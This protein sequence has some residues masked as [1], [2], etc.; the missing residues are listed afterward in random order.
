MSKHN[1]VNMLSGPIFKNIVRFTVP[2]IL[3]SILQLLFN[4][5]DLIVVGRFCGS[6]SVAAVGATSPLIH[7]FINFFVGISAGAGVVAANA[8]GA[9][10]TKEIKK[11]VH[12]AIPLAFI[13]GA[14]LS[15]VG[16]CFSTPLLKL[17]RTPN[18]ILVLSSKYM[19]IYFAGM[20]ATMLYNFCAAILRAAGDTKSPLLALSTSGVIN[21]VLNII[22]VVLFH[23]DVVGVALATTIS[24]VVS[25]VLVLIILMRRND[26]C[27]FRFTDIKIH[28]N[29][30]I[31]ILH[32][33]VPG[34]IQS[35]LFSISNVLIQSSI[36]SFGEAMISGSSAASNIEGF[37]YVI[38]DSFGIAA[39]NFA[40]QNAGIKN[41]IRVQK[42]Y[43]T[44]LFSAFTVA[45]VIGIGVRIFGERL[46]SIYITD[47]NE[48]ISFG[49]VRFTFVALLYFFCGMM[50]VTSNTIRALGHSI[51]P[52]IIT[53]LGVCAFRVVWIY[54][55]FRITSFH[56]PA[57]LYISY[58]ISWAITFVILLIILINILKKK[59]TE[60]V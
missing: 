48:A 45:F 55:V 58:P 10:N 6:I 13:S 17:M 51:K 60:K 7:L 56:T 21:V 22:F 59:I 47:S 27:K 52:M 24:Q 11:I 39:I 54:T 30:L 42:V 43:T 32:I 36:N 50:S 19:Q 53:L 40:G 37:I 16:M 31:K 29:A 14:F 5:A 2:V 8:I 15:V 18:D 46:L 4:A 28:K 3:S 33:G 9:G 41:Y 57:G 35:S 20:C 44:C 1:D 23:L 25:A 12:T 26:A 49:L 34:G 38:M